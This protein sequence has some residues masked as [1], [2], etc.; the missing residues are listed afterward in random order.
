VVVD[1]VNAWVDI[2][3]KVNLISPAEYAKHRGV[4]KAAVSKAIKAQRISL[5]EGKI[6]AAVADMQWA[7]NSRVRAGSGRP[8]AATAGGGAAARGGGVVIAVLPRPLA[9]DAG[10]GA[11]DPDAQPGGDDYWNSRSRREAAEAE[12]AEIELAEKTGQVIAVKAVESVWAQALASMREHLLQVRARLAP[13]LAA[14]T[15]AFQIDQMLDLE[16]NQALQLMAGV[17]LG[18]T[19]A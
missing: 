12:L 10:V 11:G 14:E 2:V 6:D 19:A 8:G 15:D 9:G 16:H 13:L 17:S 4:S 3:S 1:F 7:R 5:I 18:K